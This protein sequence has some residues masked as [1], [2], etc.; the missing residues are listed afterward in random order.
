MV[1][2]SDIREACSKALLDASTNFKDNHRKA[3]ELALK[4]ETNENSKW[5]IKMILENDL[6]A[7]EKQTPHCDDTGIPYILLEV[8]EDVEIE[9]NIASIFSSVEQGIADGLRTLPGRPMAVKGDDFERIEQSK[10]LYEDSGMLLPSPIR[11]KTIRGNQLK[12]SVLMMG[13]GPEIRAKTYRVFHHHSLEKFTDEIAGWAVEMA[14]KLGCTPCVPAI[15]VG[16]THYEAT[17]MMLDA[18]TYGKFGEE[19]EFEKKIT[20]AVNGSD[21]GALGI[22]GD[23]TALQTFARIGEQRASGVRIVSLRLGCIFD[24]RRSTVIL[25]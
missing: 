9:G 24:P 8:G 10:G 7:K 18:M 4:N 12:I 16:R 14:K 11:V 22:G 23:V 20:K 17:C 1:K 15:G 19:N 2:L 6:I 13:G 5:I 3:Y 21:T 25:G